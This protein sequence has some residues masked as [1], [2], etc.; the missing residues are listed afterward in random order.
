M[1]LA[2]SGFVLGIRQ[3]GAV[4]PHEEIIPAHVGKIASEVVRDG[5][6]KDP[7]IL[8][9]D[10]GAVL[11]GMHRLAA[12]VRLGLE[13]AVCCSVD[14]SSRAITLGRWARV[15]ETRRGDSLEQSLRPIDAPRRTTLAEAF[16]ALERK[17]VGLA[18]FTADAAF[19][20]SGK[21]DLADAF[22]MV[23]AFDSLGENMGWKRDFVPEDDIDIPLQAQRNL[24][25]LVRRL[26]KDD[27]VTA[28]RSGRLFPCK[29]SMHRVDP[30]PVAVNF[31]ISGLR[32]AT[33]GTLREFLG[34]RAGKLLPGGSFYEGRRYK[35]RLLVLNHE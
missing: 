29:T 22:R 5:V 25:V 30:R 10:S 26:G 20:P 9:G 32:K 3:V 6:Q 12:F 24:V 13:N 31:P 19:L 2:K 34:G 23:G 33:T 15:Y 17:E 27:V 11:D 28:A 21:T 7:I 4:L 18:A 1:T 16:E 35:E 8:D 14:Y